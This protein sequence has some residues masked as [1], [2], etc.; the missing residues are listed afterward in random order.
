M[1]GSSR[2]R[3]EA[4][5]TVSTA[6]HTDRATLAHCMVE[7]ARDL[8]GAAPLTGPLDLDLDITEGEGLPFAD[9]MVDSLGFV[10]WM[11]ELEEQ[12]DMPLM[13]V[14][15]T[16]QARTLGGLADIVLRD[17]DP[18]LLAAFRS[19]WAQRGDDG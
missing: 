2:S 9:Y 18:A 5:E 14:A 7:C 10:Q 1:T 16:E 4:V 12:L 13:D 19:R 6:Q 15:D 3:I 11:A 17:G 8:L